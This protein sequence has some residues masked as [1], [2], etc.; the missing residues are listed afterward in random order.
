M[1]ESVTRKIRLL[2]AAGAAAALALA[3]PAVASADDGNPLLARGAV[4]EAVSGGNWNIIFDIH[5]RGHGHSSEVAVANPSETFSFDGALC[6]GTYTDPRLGGTTV[7]VVGA[8]TSYT[9]P[10]GADNDPYYA[11]KVHKGGPL[12]ADYSW[13]DVPITSLAAAQGVCANPAADLS[14]AYFAL[15]AADVHWHV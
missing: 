3:V 12:G 10:G 2:A 6:A 4:T 5:A 13:V 7:Y 14:A 9:G 15:V 11:F 1:G 8:R